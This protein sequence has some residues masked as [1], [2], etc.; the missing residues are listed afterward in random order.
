MRANFTPSSAESPDAPRWASDPILYA[1]Q[2]KRDPTR[3]RKLGAGSTF[4]DAYYP[5]KKRMTK[6]EKE[7]RD[8]DKIDQLVNE[9]LKEV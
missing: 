6:S 8:E 4:C 9:R 3:G 1:L 7:R 2:R 5:P